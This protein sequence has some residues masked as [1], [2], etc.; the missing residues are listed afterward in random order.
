MN[1]LRESENDTY[2]KAFIIKIIAVEIFKI[3]DNIK[4]LVY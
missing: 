1:L 2:F 3:I 4:K